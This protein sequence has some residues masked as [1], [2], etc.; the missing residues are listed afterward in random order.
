MALELE[1][2]HGHDPEL[3]RGRQVERDAAARA[4]PLAR[5]A[6]E[7]LDRGQVAARGAGEEVE[8]AAALA[9]H[10]GQARADL[11]A[12]AGEA[13]RVATGV[14]VEAHAP[15]LTRCGRLL[16]LRADRLV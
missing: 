10:H 14:E 15:E 16:L 13:A 9:A 8:R 6:E 12:L 3:A 11:E 2:G 5:L 7:E 4:A 1:P